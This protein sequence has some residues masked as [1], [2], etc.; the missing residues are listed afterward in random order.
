M[1]CV[2]DFFSILLVVVYDVVGE[3]G[4][5]TIEANSVFIHEVRVVG[6]SCWSK[7][8]NSGYIEKCWVYHPTRNVKGVVTTIPNYKEDINIFWPYLGP[9]FDSWIMSKIPMSFQ[10][11]VFFFSTL[12]S[13]AR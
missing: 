1:L 4:S 3:S 13:Q 7:T 6:F 8:S 12:A 9:T 11:W 2:R 10:T 5:I